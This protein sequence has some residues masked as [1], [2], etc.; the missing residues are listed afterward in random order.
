MLTLL[1][2]IARLPLWFM[3][4]F[5]Q[6]VYWLSFDVFRWR[7]ALALSNLRNAFPDLTEAQRVAIARQS[8]RNLA[9]LLA[10]IFKGARLGADEMRQRVQF[11]NPDVLTRYTDR[12]QSV[13]LLASHHCN[14]E[15]LLLAAGARFG[16]PVD[17]VYK[18]QRVAPIDQFLR[19]TRSRF[20]GRPIPVKE[21]LLEV[22]KRKGEAHAFAL[23]ADQTP[24]QNDDKYWTRFLNQDT[25][26]FLGPEKIARITRSPVLF[27]AM[28]RLRR[29]YYEA[30]FS[31][32]AAPPYSGDGTDIIERYARAVEAQIRS[33]PGDWLW[34][35]RKWKYRK[36]AYA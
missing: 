4:V 32:L 9:Q 8:Y 11:V 25:A 6:G 29:G 24:L 28:R 23:V 31:E 19:E 33:S 17:A 14:W 3:Y 18:P 7:R 22:L 5:N 15:W 20:G 21:F 36:P 26:F 30:E 16:I 34:L 27:V 35:H 12:G 13:V 1:R 2:L 10:E